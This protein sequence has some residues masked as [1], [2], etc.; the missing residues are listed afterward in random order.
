MDWALQ[1]LRLDTLGNV[2]DADVP[3][4]NIIRE[5]VTVKKFV[6]DEELEPEPPKPAATKSAKGKGKKA[7]Q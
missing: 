1:I 2:L 6:Y 7:K 3:L 4:M 5:Q